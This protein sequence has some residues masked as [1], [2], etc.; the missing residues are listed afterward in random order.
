MTGPAQESSSGER[1]VHW[2]LLFVALLG[3]VVLVR[4][5]HAPRPALVSSVQPLAAVPPG[6]MLLVSLELERLGARGAAELLGEQGKE[7]LGLRELCGLEPLLGLRH[8]VLAVPPARDAAPSDFALIADT[9]LELEPV[10]RCAEALVSKRGGSPVRSRIGRFVSVR[11]QKK[12]LGEMAMRDDGLFVLSGGQYFR[13]VVDAA[14]GVVAPID[15]AARLRNQLHAGIRRRLSPS[16]LL[17]TLLPEGQLPLP[18]VQAVGLGFE[19][20]ETVRL[21][22]FVGCK[23]ERDCAAARE[24]I[25]GLRLELQRDAGLSGLGSAQLEQ[26]G[27]E[28]E[29]QAELPREQLVPLLLALAN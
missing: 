8:V 7:L 15:E 24:V 26:H 23:T 22:G 1:V 28:L 16:Q 13:D 29:L 9:S 3:A 18:G 11:D 25:D 27:L 2:L 21:R 20:G 6:P 12:P 10:L 14:S 4:R 5:P 17:L 19:L